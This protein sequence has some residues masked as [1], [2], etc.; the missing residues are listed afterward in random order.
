MRSVL[1]SLLL[2]CAFLSFASSALA[3][4]FIPYYGKTFYQQLDTGLK[5]QPLRDQLGQT[6]K[7]GHHSVGYTRAQVFI[8]N[9]F[10]P[11]RQNGQTVVKD[12]YCQ[13]TYPAPDILKGGQT[14]VVVN[15]EHTWPQSK[16]TGTSPSEVQKS[17]LH[18]LFPADAHIN[19]DRGN[20]PFGEVAID[21]K[22]LQ[23]QISRLGNS[24]AGQQVVFEPPTS[25][26]G[27]VARAL[28]Y[29]AVR[30]QVAIDDVQES[31]LRKWD[32]ED[33]VD[34]EEI[35]RNEAIFKLQGNRNPFIDFPGIADR[36][37]NF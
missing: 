2:F 32:H 28:F 31:Y 37:S 14:T 13:R 7:T 21:Q 15:V 18:H 25:H 19:S 11:Y 33:P 1:K 4:P 20:Y 5:G 16:F 10:Y 24:R 36:I 35:R 23:C 8:F 29:F 12:V 6:T 27:H 22:S 9:E 26:K 30:Y 17:D 34:E 3:A